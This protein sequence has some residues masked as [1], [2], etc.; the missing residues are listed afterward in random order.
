MRRLREKVFE[1]TSTGG[2]LLYGGWI[3]ACGCPSFFAVHWRLA[4]ARAVVAR[5]GGGV[6]SGGGS[7]T[8]GGF[9]GSSRGG[10]GGSSIGDG[11]SFTGDA[12]SILFAMTDKRITW[13]LFHRV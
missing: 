12:L 2:L 1:A 10:F 3:I 8:G 13:T 4:M 5:I 9:G 6:L 11:G 7:F